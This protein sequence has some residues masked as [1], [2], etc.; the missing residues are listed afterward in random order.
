[1]R[2]AWRS[3]P[4]LPIP[5]L[6]DFCLI[7]IITEDPAL[8]RS[9]VAHVNP[10]KLPLLQELQKSYVP[11]LGKE[12]PIVNVLRTGRSEIYSEVTEWPDNSD[13]RLICRK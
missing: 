12:H 13:S 6:C 1:M 7:D 5:Y 9:A 3:W 4:I 10:S 8:H 2:I 11:D